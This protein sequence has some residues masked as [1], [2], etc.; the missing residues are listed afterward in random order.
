MYWGI[1]QYYIPTTKHWP[2]LHEYIWVHH[3]LSSQDM[4]ATFTCI[5]TSYVNQ[6]KIYIFVVCFVC[7]ICN[8]AI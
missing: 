5:H 8:H 3:V 1:E 7:Y 6:G 2:Y 4:Y